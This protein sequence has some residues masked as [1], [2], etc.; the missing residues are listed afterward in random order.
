[1]VRHRLILPLLVYVFLDFS[2]PF[3][4]GAVNFNPD[5]SVDGVRHREL[6]ALSAQS[7]P[8]HVSIVEDAAAVLRSIAPRVV[9]IRRAH[10]AAPKLID[11]SSDPPPS[12]D[13]H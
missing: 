13:D 4:P 6:A 7:Q 11:R 12:P 8:T 10:A 5:E 2:N 1:M 3:M 9:M